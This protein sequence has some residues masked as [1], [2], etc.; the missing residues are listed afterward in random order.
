[1]F[2]EAFFTIGRHGISLGVQQQMNGKENHTHTQIEHYLVIK[3]NVIM[4]FS[5]R[6]MELESIMLSEIRQTQKDE[7][8]IFS[9]KQSLHLK[10]ISR[11]TQCKTGTD[12]WEK[13]MRGL[14][15]RVKGG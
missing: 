10:K 15:E 4:S 11:M 5:G 8:H 12:E 7:Y 2:I 3:K 14:R 1:V 9:P 13:I 6:W